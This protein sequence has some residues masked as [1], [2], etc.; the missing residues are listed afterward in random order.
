MFLAPVLL[1]GSVIVSTEQNEVV[2]V[3]LA[4]SSVFS[5]LIS[6]LV[7]K[8]Q[9]VAAQEASTNQ[10]QSNTLVVQILRVLCCTVRCQPPGRHEA[11]LRFVA[12]VC[13]PC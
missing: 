4:L 6:F 10:P 5:F 2:L 8:P 3:Q 7:Y 9:I 12:N 11:L 13:D 1:T